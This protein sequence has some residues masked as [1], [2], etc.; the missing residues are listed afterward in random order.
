MSSVVWQGFTAAVE[1]NLY[2]RPNT[3]YVGSR[4]AW[5]ESAREVR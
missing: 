2:E 5:R 3:I 1:P 4:R